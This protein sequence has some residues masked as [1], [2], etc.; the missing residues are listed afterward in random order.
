MVPRIYNVVI[1]SALLFIVYQGI[2]R[3]EIQVGS[4]SDKSGFIGIQ[5]MT[6]FL[7]Q[8]VK[9]FFLW[10]DPTCI[11]SMKICPILLE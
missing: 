8:N 11:K 5:N 3:S 9:T 1:R 7:F 10:P 2:Y 6:F 4:V